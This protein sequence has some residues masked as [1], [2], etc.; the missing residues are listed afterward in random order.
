MQILLI[1]QHDFMG[2]T[3]ARQLRSFSIV[4]QVHL[5]DGEGKL[6]V[7]WAKIQRVVL[8]SGA[9]TAAKVDE[10]AKFI[11]NIAPKIP[12]LC[13]GG[14][15]AAM[16]QAFGTG[17]EALA[18]PMSGEA[19]TLIVG[20]GETPLF[21]NIPR[22]VSVGCYTR[23]R[24][25]G[26]LPNTLVSL[27]KDPQDHIW[28]IRH[29]S[30]PCTGIGFHPASQLTPHG[31][32]MLANWLGATIQFQPQTLPQQIPIQQQST[33]IEVKV[34]KKRNPPTG[35]EKSPFAK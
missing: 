28:G 15:M 7:D 14:G 19:C 6:E 1:H 16:A 30:C 11:R 22:E 8:A 32:Q 29:V 21:K 31:R 3:L 20:G 12:M 27:V 18:E 9:Q 35:L 24:I 5:W 13:I 25:K 17:I 23:W 26:T 10:W 33:K 4:Q 2:N 34:G